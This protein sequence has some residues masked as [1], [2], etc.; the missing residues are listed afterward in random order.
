MPLS[1]TFPSVI[2]EGFP[3]LPATLLPGFVSLS[4]RAVREQTKT[5]SVFS[6]P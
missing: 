3:M 4:F 6:R 5:G 2:L 1:A